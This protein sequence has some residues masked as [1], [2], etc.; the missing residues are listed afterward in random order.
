MLMAGTVIAYQKANFLFVLVRKGTRKAI[1]KGKK[2]KV[3]VF[4]LMPVVER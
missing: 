4:N 2:I 3:N 1:K